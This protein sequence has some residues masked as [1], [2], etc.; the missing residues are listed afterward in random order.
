MKKFFSEFGQFV[1]KGNVLDLAVGIVMGTAF[2]AIIKSL[3]ADIIMPFIGLIAKTD[4]T[5]L[6]AV[7]R[8]TAVY[9]EALGTLILSEDAVLLRYGN[10]IQS[11][12]DFLIIAFAIFLTIRFLGRIKTKLEK[13]KS[14]LRKEEEV[15]TVE[16]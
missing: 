11:I 12:I 7:L 10:F 5:N 3:V 4:I 2:N 8:G 15:V 14:A 1:A 13:A 9:D 6:Y 16:E